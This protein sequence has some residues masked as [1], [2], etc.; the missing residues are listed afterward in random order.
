MAGKGKKLFLYT[1]KYRTIEIKVS[2]FELS[3]YCKSIVTHYI[4]K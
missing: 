3:T 4:H 1:G 2:E